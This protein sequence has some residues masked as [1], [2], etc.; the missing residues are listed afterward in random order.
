MENEGDT[1]FRLGKVLKRVNDR[2]T[3]HLMA[4]QKAP[5]HV[6]QKSSRLVGKRKFKLAHIDASDNTI[7]FNRR[8]KPWTMEVDTSQKLVIAINLEVNK[9]GTLTTESMGRI[10]QKFIPFDS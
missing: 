3:L 10:P 2:H 6:R 7:V 9:N 8:H 5:K 1:K 4:A